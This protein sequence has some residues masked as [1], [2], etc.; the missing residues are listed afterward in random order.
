MTYTAQKI[1]KSKLVLRSAVLHK[2]KLFK[3]LR[4]KKQF[5]LADI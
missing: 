5:L 2:N 1:K 4:K 3:I